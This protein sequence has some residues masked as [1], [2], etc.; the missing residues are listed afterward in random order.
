MKWGNDR[1]LR[2]NQLL[3]NVDL[4]LDSVVA[5][6]LKFSPC[7]SRSTSFRIYK[8]D[9]ARGGYKRRRALCAFPIGRRSRIEEREESSVFLAESLVSDSR[10]T[11]VLLCSPHRSGCCIPRR[12]SNAGTIAL[13]VAETTEI[14]DSGSPPPRDR[15]R[16]R[17]AQLS[18]ETEG[19]CSNGRGRRRN[20]GCP[21]GTNRI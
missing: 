7:A 19:S 10:P 13:A 8:G 9:L 6:S 12:D 15:L 4:F 3:R 2:N 18:R 17:V 1:L 14:T 5:F 11:Y 21:T 20:Y 16:A